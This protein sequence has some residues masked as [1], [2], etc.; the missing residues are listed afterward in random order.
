MRCTFL[1]GPAPDESEGWVERRLAAIKAVDVVGYSRLKG[2]DEGGTFAA[3]RVRRRPLGDPKI[4]GH[5]RRIVK[6]TGNGL[7]LEVASVAFGE[8]T[9]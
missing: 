7:P 9:G 3:L 4:A 2:A 6:T 8:L 1:A 5:R